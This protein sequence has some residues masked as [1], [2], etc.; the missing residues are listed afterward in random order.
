M[1]VG[2]NSGVKTALRSAQFALHKVQY[3]PGDH[4]KIVPTGNLV[5][6]QINEC[7]PG[8]VVQHLLEVRDA[9][10]RIDGVAVKA[11]AELIAQTASRH[12]LQRQGDVI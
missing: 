7:Q 2:V 1:R 10:A 11:A 8:I 3:D 12:L 9:P 6:L 4:R 5:S